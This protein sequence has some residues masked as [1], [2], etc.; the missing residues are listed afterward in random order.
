MGCLIKNIALKIPVIAF[1]LILILIF[2]QT[3]Y[4]KNI[5]NSID[6]LIELKDF[7]IYESKFDVG[8]Y[9]DD[10][11]SGL[12]FKKYTEKYLSKEKNVKKRMYTL[13]T[14]FHVNENLN[15]KQLSLFIGSIS[16]PCN[17]YLNG[18]MIYKLGRYGENYNSTIY[19][20]S[21]ILLQKKLLYYG[22]KANLLA[23]QL[24]PLY[25][26]TP[27]TGL[28]ISSYDKVSELVFWR[29]FFN[30]YLIRA[31]A[32]SCLIIF[33]FFLFGF[34]ARKFMEKRYLYFAL[35]CLF[36]IL[37]Y[38][39]IFL[40]HDS[41]NERLLEKISR[42]GFPMLI[43]FFT[44]FIFEF[45]AILNKKLWLKLAIL[46]PTSVS[47]IIIIFLS[48]K[49][50]LQGFFNKIM[51][52]IIAPLLLVN[53]VILVYSVIKK[54][55]RSS[56]IVLIAFLVVLGTSAFDMIHLSLKLTPYTWLVPYGFISLVLALFFL[57]A[58]E[59][60]TIYFESV[61]RAEELNLSNN[62]LKKVIENI[63]LFSQNLID[64]SK[65]LEENLK[66]TIEFS[67]EYN[68]SNQIIL[69]KIL[70]EFNDIEKVI[71]QT[72]KRI[73]ESCEKIPKA[74][75]NQTA[76]VEETTSTINYVVEHLESI[77]NS[78]VQTNEVAKQL[79]TIADKSSDI[80]V[81]SKKSIGK[82]SEHSKFIN[83][84]L[85][86]IEEITEQTNLLAMNASIE[87]AR[88]G[89]AGRGF[90]IVAGEIRNL[91][92]KSKDSLS[93]SFDKIQEMTDIISESSTLSDKVSTSL[94][95]IIEQSM[96]S[97]KMIDNITNLIKEQKEQSSAVLDATHSLLE[98]TLTIK[99]LS[100]EEQLHNENTKNILTE[101]QNSFVSI[102]DLLK[103][104][105][106]KE[107][108]LKSY[109]RNIRNIM[110]ENLKNVEILNKT[111]E[112]IKQPIITDK[113]AIT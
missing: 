83:V 25:E 89:N 64:S 16:Y 13:R 88:A 113:K 99:E 111:V 80:V 75:L 94:F 87:A 65:V 112:N 39:N 22:E 14:N 76:V 110:E 6:E 10:N 19:Y 15:N 84:L 56:I 18:E 90:S 69:D 98:D 50:S 2:N 49:E 28:K 73:E 109:I 11:I 95:S 4:S 8:K 108:D 68:Q 48:T 33:A 27:L 86:N 37:S 55:N 52:I 100:D 51:L 32:L 29:N 34:I 24:Y 44:I 12:D 58:K 79:S 31:S 7:I 105:K 85:S 97:A 102:T 91:S 57:L 82:L 107:E 5:I 35:V 92:I 62:D 104:Q 106:E 20:S 103:G 63:T 1:S 36:F 67:T 74:I 21:N 60:S 66:K 53:L 72:T 38:S 23:I 3:L 77:M 26:S 45:T 93:S 46:T 78:T 71:G 40:F 61:K 42:F 43:A 30:I 47:S 81:R 54:K 59:Q 41:A 96:H 101:L 17:V 70:Q 9:V